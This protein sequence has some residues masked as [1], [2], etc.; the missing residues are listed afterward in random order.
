MRRGSVA[1]Q[2]FVSATGFAMLASTLAGGIVLGAF[3]PWLIAMGAIAIVTILFGL[4]RQAAGSLRDSLASVAASV[5]VVVSAVFVYL[6]AANHSRPVDLTRYGAHSLSEQTRSYVA[7]LSV[8]IRLTVFASSDRQDDYA[9]FLGEYRRLSPMLDIRIVDPT[10]EVELAR[11]YDP[12]GVFPGEAF[13]ETLDG[14]TARVQRFAFDAMDR[15]R[16]STVTNAILRI[17]RGRDEKVYV[18]SGRGGRGLVAPKTKRPN[19]PDTSLSVFAEALERQVTTVAELNLASVDSVPDDAACVAIAAPETDFPPAELEILRNYVDEGGSLLVLLEPTFRRDLDGLLELLG[20]ACIEAPNGVLV[21]GAPGAGD[22]LSVAV[23]VEGPHPI[24][25]AC[26]NAVFAVPMAR[27]VVGASNARELAR[28]VAPLAVTGRTV[29]SED[30]VA[31]AAGR[32]QAPADPK[33]IRSW[34]VA[35]ASSWAASTGSRRAV[36]R[37]VVCGDSDFLTNSGIGD[38]GALFAV[39]C[40]N[41]LAMRDDRLAIPPRVLPPS[42]FTMTAARF[43][44][45]VGTL[46]LMSLALLAGGVGWT[47]A[48]RRSG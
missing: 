46:A 35:V 4:F 45:I 2:V 13:V 6:I 11:G 5:F 20:E 33:A 14:P 32:T 17:E 31:I 39:Q 40:V 43:W 1:A 3:P 23:R 24:A 41:W 29:W 19:Q 48:R 44:T 7:S 25:E 12:K 16:E 27:P 42:T 38:Q 22:P 18:V 47:M 15:Y 34:P 21:D 36:A 37:V 28:E 30:P 8:P 9:D 26:G 10:V